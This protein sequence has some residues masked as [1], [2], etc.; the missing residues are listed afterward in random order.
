M[1]T[2]GAAKPVVTWKPLLIC[3]N[4]ELSARITS[5][6]ASLG[7]PAVAPLR[8]YPASVTAARA[9]SGCNIVFVD[10]AT[11]P[12]RGLSVISEAAAL[13]PVVALNPSKEAD[14]ILRCLRRGA[15]EFLSDPS[16]EN[17]AAL[18]ERL[19]PEQQSMPQHRRGKVYAVIP[20][21]PGCGA[22]TLAAHLAMEFRNSAET[23]VLLVDTDSLTASISFMLKLKSEFH[24]EDILRDWKRMDQDLWSRLT[25]RYSGFDVVLAPENP[26]VRTDIGRALAAE[27]AGFWR[28]RY[29]S[30]VIDCADLR[31]GFEN[32]FASAADVLLMVTTNEL[33]T[34]H[35]TRRSFEFLDQAMPGRDR[36]R[37]ILNRYTPA[38]GLKQKD[39]RAVL[40]V[41]PFAT[42]SND[43]EA[44]QS[45]LLE[46]RPAAP[47]SRFCGSVQNLIRQL[48]GRTATAKKPENW[49]RRLTTRN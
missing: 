15:C 30:V 36:L 25:T 2:S 26:A 28:E 1:E 46:G 34:L 42:L 10:V 16:R 49:L 35:S 24:L 33:A 22:S 23:R 44:I 13:C 41:E 5:A 9:H 11:D 7:Q 29:D 19:S 8:D 17:L 21:K 39:V 3:P 37:L 20:G 40:D 32:G 47:G 12:E 4:A 18:F 6:L 27:M 38:F 45:A 48:D 31:T 14:V 43:Y